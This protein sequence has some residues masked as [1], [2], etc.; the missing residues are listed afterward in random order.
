MSATAMPESARTWTA[1]AWSRPRTSGI[2]TSETSSTCD[3]PSAGRV[4]VRGHQGPGWPATSLRHPRREQARIQRGRLHRIATCRAPTVQRAFA[5][6]SPTGRGP[7][8]C[9]RS[10]APS[11][12]AGEYAATETPHEGFPRSCPRRSP[13]RAA[14]TP[15]RCPT[16]APSSSGAAA[17][18]RPRNRR[19]RHL[20]VARA[21]RP[22][23][24][25][26]RVV[27]R[28][29]TLHSHDAPASG[30]EGSPSDA[31]PS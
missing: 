13:S 21:G 29:R 8:H 27:M 19:W 22:R 12:D 4:R 2:S 9:S 11:S 18:D 16:I 3:A 28:I 17:R 15:R 26:R 1:E 25:L 7:P 6:P 20:A 24:V 10:C 14:S 5:T 30:R 23:P 31:W